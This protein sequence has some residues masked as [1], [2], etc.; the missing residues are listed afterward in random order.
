MEACLCHKKNNK[1]GSCDFFSHNS[2][3]FSDF[4]NCEL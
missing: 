4:Q 1:K 2:D 3:G